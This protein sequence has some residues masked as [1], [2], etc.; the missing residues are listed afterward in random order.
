MSG[1]TNIEA[2]KIMVGSI[3]N[4]IKT[5]KLDYDKTYTGKVKTSLGNNTYVVEIKGS[6]YNLRCLNE[7]SLNVNDIVKV[8]SPQG[9]DTNMFILGKI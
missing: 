3:L 4:M 9:N 2:I 8:L 5:T 7:A 1:K 6:D